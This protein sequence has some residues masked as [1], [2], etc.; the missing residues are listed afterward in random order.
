MSKNFVTL[1]CAA[2]LALAPASGLLAQGNAA[3]SAANSKVFVR[4]KTAEGHAFVSGGVSIEDR[5]AMHAEQKKYT[6]WVA[7]VARPSGAYL[8]DAKLKI[9]DS[10]GGGT[11]V[12]RT[13]EG[14]WYMV[15]LPPG[16]YKVQ[17]T[18]RADGSKTDQTLSQTINV[19]QGAVRQVVLRFDSKATVSPEMRSPFEGNPFGV[20][21]K[22]K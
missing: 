8:A 1:T 18:F 20:P 19:S 4:D 3:T 10:K 21:A 15:A 7:T 6:L 16:R 14:P 22:G 11:L 17:A 2:L 12:E 9:I 13:M 5:Q